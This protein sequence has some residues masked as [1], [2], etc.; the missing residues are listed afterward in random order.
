MEGTQQNR[1]P[2]RCS[3]LQRLLPLHQIEKNLSVL[4]LPPRHQMQD[5]FAQ[6][7][8]SLNSQ[9]CRDS[10]AIVTA[11]QSQLAVSQTNSAFLHSV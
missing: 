2:H 7:Q 11:M 8:L 1:L 9:V 6:I 10:M 4:D 3:N 5:T